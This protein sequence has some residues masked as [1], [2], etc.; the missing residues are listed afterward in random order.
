ME[1]F[2]VYTAM[3][4]AM[5][6]RDYA[7]AQK[8]IMMASNDG[9]DPSNYYMLMVITFEQKK[10]VD[11]C[12]EDHPPNFKRFG[13]PKDASIALHIGKGYLCRPRR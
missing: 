6:F 1:D 12:M 3:Q 9:S 7:G 13:D 10:L 8:D 11:F 5:R 4:H 2:N